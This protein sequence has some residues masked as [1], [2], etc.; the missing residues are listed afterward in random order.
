M[1]SVFTKK[2]MIKFIYVILQNKD[3]IFQQPYNPAIQ[4]IT[5]YIKW[6]DNCQLFK[7]S[8]YICK[9]NSRKGKK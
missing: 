9:L 7:N 1:S 3:D 8:Q 5:Q 2:L 6:H 4:V